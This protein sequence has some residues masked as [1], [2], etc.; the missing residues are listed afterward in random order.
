MML[1]VN[2]QPHELAGEGKLADLLREVGCDPGRT[3]VMVNGQVV[4][5]GSWHAV[6]LKGNDQVELIVF[7]GGG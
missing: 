4:P 6:A 1:S 5:R 3:A 2:G 7:A